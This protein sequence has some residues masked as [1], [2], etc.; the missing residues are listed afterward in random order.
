MNVI[1]QLRSQRTKILLITVFMKQLER[2]LNNR[3]RRGVWLTWIRLSIRKEFGY[4]QI[5]FFGEF[6]C[7]F[8][9]IKKYFC[10]KNFQIFFFRI[11]FSFLSHANIFLI[12]FK[13]SFEVF[14]NI[15]LYLM[16]TYGSVI[17]IPFTSCGTVYRFI[18]NLVGV[19]NSSLHMLISVYC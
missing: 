12:I 9:F 14:L 10:Y 3:C 7:S 2:C 11:F 4:S 5:F 6:S 19:K 8:L 13:I 17:L 18:R 16:M 1:P 15:I